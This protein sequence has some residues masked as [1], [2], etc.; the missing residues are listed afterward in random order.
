MEPQIKPC[1]LPTTW[2]FRP[3]N[4]EIIS[5]G[6]IHELSHKQQSHFPVLSTPLLSQ[7]FLLADTSC[8]VLTL[9][10]MLSLLNSSAL[11]PG[12]LCLV[13]QLKMQYCAHRKDGN[14]FPAAA[15]IP[16]VTNWQ[17]Q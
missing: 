13:E 7:A 16:A 8:S 11:L 4:D 15:E 9:F 1:F 6:V 5:F 17:G 10:P 14:S 2:S 12:E 3:N